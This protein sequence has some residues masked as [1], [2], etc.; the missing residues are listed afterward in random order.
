[1]S[2]NKILALIFKTM[3]Y[4]L[5]LQNYITVEGVI[6]CPKRCEEH[7]QS[8]LDKVVGYVHILK[9]PWKLVELA[10]IMLP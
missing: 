6:V 8:K 5:D 3:D 10:D 4:A 2:Q 7:A 1:M 9:V